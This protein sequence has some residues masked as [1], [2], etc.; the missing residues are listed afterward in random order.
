MQLGAREGG[1]AIATGE[2]GLTGCLRYIY[3]FNNQGTRADVDRHWHAANES[4]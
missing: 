1:M 4:R 2:L 3:R